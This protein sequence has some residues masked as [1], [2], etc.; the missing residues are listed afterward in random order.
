MPQLLR[1][2]WK[3]NVREL[4]NV[5]KRACAMSP[6][7]TITFAD[8]GWRDQECVADLDADDLNDLSYREAKENVLAQFSTRYLEEALR[9]TDGNVTRAAR[10]SGLERQS[11]QQIMRKYGIR[12]EAFR[13]GARK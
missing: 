3:G 11:F 13:K 12:S 2:E 10:A 5:I 7:N 8:L 4:E 9:K 1:H 6:G